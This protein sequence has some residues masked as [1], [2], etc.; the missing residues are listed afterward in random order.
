[1][2]SALPKLKQRKISLWR[3]E[4]GN[5]RDRRKS[6]TRRINN[7]KAWT[8]DEDERLRE[9]VI[10]NASLFDIADELGRTVVAVKARAHAIGS[11][12]RR[13]RFRVKEK[14]K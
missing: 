3:R 6:T 12:L 5:E 9:S 14:A 11:A 2:L 10:S 4:P 7:C 13:S 1:V 8:S